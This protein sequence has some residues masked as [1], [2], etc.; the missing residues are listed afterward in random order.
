MTPMSIK[1]L[2]DS[3][4]RG[5][6]GAE[7]DLAYKSPYDWPSIIGFYRSHSIPGIEQVTENSFARAFRIEN[8]V[9]FVRIRPAK[10][11]PRLTVR[12]VPGDPKIVSGVV[13]RIRKMFDLDCDPMEI[14]NSFRRVPLLAALCCRYPGLRLPRGWDAFETAV[15]SILGQLVSAEQRANLI[16][17]MVSNYGTEIVNPV[18]ATP[19]RLFPDTEILASAD[20]SA[21]KTTTARRAAIREFSRRVLSGAIS[22]A[23]SQDPSAFR[24]AL[25]ETRGLGPWS[26]EYISL[27]AI[28]DT[29]AF[30]KTDLILKRVLELHPDLD[31]EL[32]KP[33][34]SY[35][36]MYLWK[37]FAQRLSKRKKE[38]PT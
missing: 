35:A 34:K 27:R 16:G 29:D 12:I 36:A 7:I 21:V 31:L 30:P 4:S 2:N 28:G 10:G 14:A 9:G 37:E 15:C 23:D 18:T 19:T 32:I 6:G 38:K 8:T 20:L 26:A 25:L 3:G 13:N 1:R 11:I 24:Q 17:Q 22:L 5:L 33:W